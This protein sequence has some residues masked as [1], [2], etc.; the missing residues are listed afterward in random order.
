[1]AAASAHRRSAAATAALSA[2]VAT[3]LA[4]GAQ[5]QARYDFATQVLTVP[6]IEAGGQVYRNLTARLDADGRLTILTLD[7][8]NVPVT[9][10]AAAATATAQSGTNACAPI[11]PFYWEI[12][13]R[14]QRL[15]SGSVPAAGNPTQVQA[16]TVME[17][18]SATKWLYGAYVVERRGGQLTAE[19]V[20]HLNFTSGYTG[21]GLLGCLPNDSVGQC[22]ERG[23]NGVQD[24]AHL[25]R[26]YYNGAHMQKHASL[27]APGM[28]LG[29][30]TNTT[31]AAELRRVLAPEMNLAFV[32]PQL[33]GGAR[34]SAN[35]YAIFLRRLLN[36]QLQLGALLGQHPVCTNPATCP[37]AIG[38]PVPA[39]LS[40]H[41]SLGHWVEDDPVSGDAAYSSA[42]AFGFYPWIDAGRTH[43][44][45][46][47]RLAYA[48]SG[49]ASA[50]C[51]AL[52]R[53]AWL[54]GTPQ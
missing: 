14:G 40:W 45:V 41:Y 33:A 28:A 17:I 1:M 54:S 6:S 36:N 8:P 12:G 15:A 7:A 35:D 27:P 19:D 5:A 51:G 11:R 4:G 13:D 20:R 46:L 38:T 18:A 44:G 52:V 3:S 29:A 9:T 26:F 48:G 37:S 31:L 39:G 43:Y 25:D 16:D 30:L 2:L 10:R 49:E 50:A 21:F 24:P 47:A 34:M 42:G 22:A 32:Q 53:R 23:S